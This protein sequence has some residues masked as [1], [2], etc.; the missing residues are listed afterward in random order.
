MSGFVSSNKTISPVLELTQLT[1]KRLYILPS[2]SS[3][4][5]CMSSINGSSLNM[6][7]FS[8]TPVTMPAGFQFSKTLLIL[9]FAQR[10]LAHSAISFSCPIGHA[11]TTTALMEPAL[12]PVTTS[13]L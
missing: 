10:L 5:V 7:L 8:R 6:P 12:T 4:T 3:N 2:L 13:Y 1:T 9:S 11:A